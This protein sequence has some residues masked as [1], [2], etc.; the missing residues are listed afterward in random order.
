MRELTSVET[1]QVNGAGFV[2][3]TVW[4]TVNAM[5]D[6]PARTL[7][8]TIGNIAGDCVGIIVAAPFNFVS[9]LFKKLGF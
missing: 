5:I 7:G 4:N 6:L 9:S 1:E 2:S 8:S 3:D